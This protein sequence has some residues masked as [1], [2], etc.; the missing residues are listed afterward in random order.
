MSRMLDLRNVFEWV[1]N[2]LNDGTLSVQELIHQ[3]H[4]LILDIVLGFGDDF[5]LTR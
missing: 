2:R 1:N 3:W 4:Q 5:Q